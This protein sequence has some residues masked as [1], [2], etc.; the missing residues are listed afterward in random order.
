MNQDALLMCSSGSGTMMDGEAT[1]MKAHESIP[2]RLLLVDDDIV[3]LR[4][5]AMHLRSHGFVVDVATTFAQAQVFLGAIRYAAVV[6]DLH[7]PADGPLAGLRVA[8]LASVRRPKVDPFI[9]L[10][11]GDPSLPEV[12]VRAHGIDVVL[13]KGSLGDLAGTVTAGL[14]QRETVMAS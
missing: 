3:V 7:M 13:A 1:A 8:D 12:E 10:C 14:A 5:A 9:V 2:I 4:C 6:T 11:T